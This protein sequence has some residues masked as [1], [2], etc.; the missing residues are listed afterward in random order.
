MLSVLSFPLNLQLTWSTCAKTQQAPCSAVKTLI[1]GQHGWDWG[2]AP[3]PQQLEG[4]VNS[5]WFW[6][7]D[8]ANAYL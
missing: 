7:H 4:R 1:K 8:F 6:L 5:G 3:P 2:A